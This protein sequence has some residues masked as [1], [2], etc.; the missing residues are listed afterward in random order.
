VSGNLD[1]TRVTEL[2]PDAD[3]GH[4]EAHRS[5]LRMA[6]RLAVQNAG[7]LRYAHGLGW[8]VWDGTRWAPDRDGEPMRAAIAVVKQAVREAAASGDDELTADLRQAEKAQALA[9]IL[10]IA[11][12]LRPLAVAAAQLDTDPLLFNTAS[13][14]LDLRTG[15]L[16]AHDQADLITKV[17]GCGFDPDAAGPA[18][19]KFITEVLPDPK[20]REF[21]KRVFGYAMLGRVVEHI[22]PILVG[23]GCNGKTTLVEVVKAAFGDYA[24][25]AE[26]ELLIERNYAH[27]TGQ[28]DLLGVRLAVTTESDQGRRLAVATVKRLTGG[29]KLRAR[30]M[31][32]DFFEFEPSH[33]VV[34]V[35]NHKPKVSADDPALWRRIRVVPF[36]VVVAEPDGALPERL[37][38]EL[39]RVL[40]WAHEG[41]CAYAAGGLD[42][43]EAVASRTAAYRAASDPLGRFLDERTVATLYA[44]VHARELY[45]A[46]ASWCHD[47]GEEPGSEVTF[48]DA[49]AARGFAKTKRGGYMTYIGIGLATEGEQP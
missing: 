13:G 11:A 38:L 20:V 8:L 42:A 12:C 9:G 5:H 7:R 3:P 21:T 49:M 2:F 29:D 35:T 18:F 28:A 44:H 31:R 45:A 24:I 30:R 33:T 43:P 27:P 22:L 23:S 26:P 4:V 10:R 39:P 19:D 47:A 36:D 14:T 25:S 37:S 46:W 17:A 15:E 1:P 34:M 32:Q 48:A 6:E 16:R 40:V 41:F